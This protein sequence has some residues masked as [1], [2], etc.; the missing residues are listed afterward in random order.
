MS[1]AVMGFCNYEARSYYCETVLC[2]MLRAADVVL[3]SEAVR[4][5]MS[6]KV[7]LYLE[8]C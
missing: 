4:D 3:E 2:Y 5:E 7:F 6:A 8:S 1:I